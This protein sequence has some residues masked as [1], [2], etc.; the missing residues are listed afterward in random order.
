M[1]EHSFREC[2]Q[3]GDSGGSAEFWP[4]QN[5]T[6][7]VKAPMNHLQLIGRKMTR[8]AAMQKE[9]LLR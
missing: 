9:C 8:L 6:Q 1:G 2:L 5:F 7:K 3:K 4:I